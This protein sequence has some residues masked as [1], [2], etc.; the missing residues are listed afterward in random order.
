LKE[1]SFWK[2]AMYLVIQAALL[3]FMALF[4]R[5]PPEI[6]LMMDQTFAP[7]GGILLVMT[8]SLM[9]KVKVQN[10]DKPSPGTLRG[11][12]S[13]TSPA[14]WRRPGPSSSQGIR[15]SFGL[16]CSPSRPG[17][18]HPQPRTTP[19]PGTTTDP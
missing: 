14:P 5:F 1:R 15:L 19:T 6:V 10:Q 2:L 12:S 18:P 8:L 17:L 9:K 3:T 4:S 7:P 13:G 16:S 11:P